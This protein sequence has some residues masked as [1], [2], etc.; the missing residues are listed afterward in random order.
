MEAI[1][2]NMVAEAIH[3]VIGL[4]ID[5]PEVQHMPLVVGHHGRRNGIVSAPEC[6]RTQG[7]SGSI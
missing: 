5:Q 3:A 6:K 1:Q 7:G 4:V 2:F